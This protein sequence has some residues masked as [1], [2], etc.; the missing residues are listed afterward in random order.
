MN[1]C[2]VVSS[3]YHLKQFEIHCTLIELNFQLILIKNRMG[4]IEKDI[5]CLQPHSVLPVLV[6]LDKSYKFTLLVV[7]LVLQ[8]LL[9]LLSQ[10]K[11]YIILI[12][13]NI[14]IMHFFKGCIIKFDSLQKHQM[15]CTV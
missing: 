10:T 8:E 12:Q 9:M 15:F 11:E 14:Y 1:E 3:R 7:G 4:F 13:Y 6:S 2:C 5:P